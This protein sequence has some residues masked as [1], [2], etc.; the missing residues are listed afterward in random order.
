MSATGLRRSPRQIS[1]RKSWTSWRARR[2][3]HRIADCLGRHVGR[4][5]G[6]DGRI[7][8]HRAR[9][10]AE[11][12]VTVERR[13]HGSDRAGHAGA[14]RPRAEPR[15]GLGQ[16]RIREH[17][18]ERRRLPLGTPAQ[19]LLT[20]HIGAP[21]V[22]AV[23]PDSGEHRAVFGEHF[24]HCVDDRDRRYDSAFAELGA[25]NAETTLRTSF[26]QELPHGATRPGA[27]AA[28]FR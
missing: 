9:R 12:R 22:R 27:D 18:D 20:Q 11:H 16:P 6:H 19:A 23:S 10:R 26:E 13:P 7:R 14:G 3:T 4:E 5:R 24:A 25:R 8:F 28:A 21:R 15:L 2:L 1:V 17:A